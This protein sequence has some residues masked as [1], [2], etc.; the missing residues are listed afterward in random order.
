MFGIK[1]EYLFSN[2]VMP[3]AVH[4]HLYI[5]S[6]NYLKYLYANTVRNILS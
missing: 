1:N 3:T 5:Y 2:N 6:W 4:L